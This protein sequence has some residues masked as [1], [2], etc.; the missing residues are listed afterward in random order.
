MMLRDVKLD[1]DEGPRP[2]ITLADFVVSDEVVRLMD[3][4]DEKGVRHD[5]ARRGARRSARRILLGV[6]AGAPQ[7]SFKL[8]AAP[9]SPARCRP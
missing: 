9:P 6:L 4:L 5:S 3:L 7:A 2:E 1:S 8:Q